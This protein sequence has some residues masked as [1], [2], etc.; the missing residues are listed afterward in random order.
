[1]LEQLVRARRHPEY[2]EIDPGIVLVEDA[3]HHALARAARQGRDADV[4]QFTPQ[5]QPDP[6]V[7]RDSPLGDVEPRHHLDPADHH[8]RDVRRHPQCLAQNPVD[9][10]PH[11]QTGLVWLDMD[12]RYAIARSV[13]DDPVDQPDRGRIVGGVEQIV[14][15]RQVGREHV[16]FTNAQRPCR[17]R[18]RLAIHRVVVAEQAIERVGRDRLDRKRHAERAADFEQHLGVSPFAQ[19]DRRCAFACVEH[20]AEPPGKQIGHCDERWRWRHLVLHRRDHF[21]G[22]NDRHLRFRRGAGS[23]VVGTAMRGSSILPGI[24]D[25]GIGGAAPI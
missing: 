3:Q 13:G 19:A 15:G 20:H 14:G 17:Q 24:G 11:D 8:R 9:P 23:P 16:E 4:E 1:M 10:H 21:P 6:P 5:G 18:G 22:A 7:L 25:D 2:V 12:V